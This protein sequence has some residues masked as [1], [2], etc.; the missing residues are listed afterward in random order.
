MSNR[1]SE[2]KRGLR[3]DRRIDNVSSNV[4]PAAIDRDGPAWKVANRPRVRIHS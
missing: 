1:D 2:E 3:L 4:A